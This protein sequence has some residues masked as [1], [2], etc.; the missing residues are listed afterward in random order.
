MYLINSR[1]STEDRSINAADLRRL[2]TNIADPDDRLEHLYAETDSH[3]ARL[4]LFLC[5]PD[6]AA[7]ESAAAGLCK[8]A[9]ERC[10][11]LRGWSMDYCGAGVVPGAE[12]ILLGV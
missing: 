4:A 6:L 3:E 7:A 5:H 9:L 11:E 1:L 12:K 8:R 10:P 2:F